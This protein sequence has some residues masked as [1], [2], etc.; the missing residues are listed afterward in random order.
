MRL[1][2]STACVLLFLL[3]LLGSA[4]L[5]GHLL[6]LPEIDQVSDKIHWLEKYGDRYDTL[7]LGT[8]RTNGHIHP[9][10]FDQL[11]AAAGRPT[12]S[13]NL[14]VNGM[15][16]PEDTFVLEAALAFRKT[17]LKAVIVESNFFR[18]ESPTNKNAN[19]ERIGY[20]LDL[21]RFLAVIQCLQETR[22]S[23]LA[24]RTGRVGILFYYCRKF[25]ARE[26]NLGRGL[27]L[28]KARFGNPV[29]SLDRQLGENWRGEKIG[30]DPPIQEEQWQILQEKL[31]DLAKKPS[32]AL[33]GLS[34]DQKEVYRKRR[35]IESHGGRMI[36]FTP[37]PATQNWLKPNPK[38]TG[39]IPIVSFSD[40][41]KYPEFYKREHLADAGHL[42]QIGA[43]LFTRALAEEYLKLP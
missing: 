17:P 27:N 22:D 21:E 16:P 32:E 15:R 33:Y 34:A 42:N 5:I 40:V 36:V 6:G 11:T 43:D 8:S 19:A 9:L 31:A 41:S 10:L 20:W 7:F 35:L 25:A 14:G 4:V 2:H 24:H 12:H 23:A 28:V 29:K 39:D 18:L 37:P 1:L 13:F 38:M 3:S 30:I 26:L